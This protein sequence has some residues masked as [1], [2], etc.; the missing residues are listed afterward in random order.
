VTDWL[1]ASISALQRKQSVTV[2]QK[3]PSTSPD[4]SFPL[5]IQFWHF[6]VPETRKL[7][8]A[9]APHGATRM[10]RNYFPV[11]NFHPLHPMGSVLAPFH[12]YFPL[13]A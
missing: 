11:M 10:T 13:R 3:F 2:S 9:A 12:F 7:M 4:R 6:Q 8:L 1:L 5:L